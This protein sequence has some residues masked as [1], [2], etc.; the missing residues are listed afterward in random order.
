MCL[1]CLETLGFGELPVCIAK[2]QYSFSV[3]PKA[4]GAAEGHVLPV[5]EIRLNAGAGFVVAV[6]GAMMTMPGLP[7]HPASVGVSLQPDG[8]VAGI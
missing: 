7:R 3:D 2:T 8:T 5:R 6:T 1:G 4:L